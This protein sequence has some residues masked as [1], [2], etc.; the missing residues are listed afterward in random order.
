MAQEAVG[1]FAYIVSLI[2]FIAYQIYRYTL[3]YSV[4]LILLSIFDA[5][6]I[7]LTY[8]EYRRIKSESIAK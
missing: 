1:I 3:T 8:L 2:L 6:M 4:F 7:A 5:V